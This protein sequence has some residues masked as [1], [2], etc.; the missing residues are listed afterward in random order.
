MATILRRPHFL[1]LLTAA[2]A[3]CGCAQWSTAPTGQW[4]GRQAQPRSYADSPKS[5]E[6]GAWGPGRVV[7]AIVGPVPSLPRP[8]LSGLRQ[9]GGSSHSTERDLADSSRTASSNRKRSKRAQY[10]NEQEGD[11]LENENVSREYE[12][13]DVESRVPP[14]F[15]KRKAQRTKLRTGVVPMLTPNF[16]APDG[17]A[18]DEKAK[19][20]ERSL[21]VGEGA[22]RGG[23]F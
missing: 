13:A 1:F 21:G 10:R 15:P 17:M 16:G 4:S 18:V 8:S 12:E 19:A 2:L 11:S 23:G 7:K 22:S 9:P 3:C 20:I 5:S 14:T 6:G